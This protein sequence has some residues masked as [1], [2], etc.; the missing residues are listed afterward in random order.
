[1]ARSI[2]RCRDVLVA[3]SVALLSASLCLADEPGAQ[4]K[5]VMVEKLPNVPGKS[6]S[7]VLVSYA[8]GAKSARHHHAGS[9]LVYVLSGAIRSE[10]SATGP[11]KVYKAGES[12]FEPAG[13]EHLISE[14]A[15]T[16]EPASL[17]AV[18]V[19]DDGAQLTTFD[20]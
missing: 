20:K 14:N 15:S 12:F 10:N 17:L 5:P 16:V 3:V 1:M 18:F 6:I 7:A 19:A 11:A 8:P 2:R 13:S 9:V 4:V